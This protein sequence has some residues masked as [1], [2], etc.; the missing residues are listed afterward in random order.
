MRYIVPRLNASIAARCK[1][2][3][4]FSLKSTFTMLWLSSPI[5]LVGCLGFT[6]ASSSSKHI[7]LVHFLNGFHNPS[8]SASPHFR[9][10]YY[11]RPALL[12]PHFCPAFYPCDTRTPAPPHLPNA[13]VNPL[14]HTHIQYRHLKITHHSLLCSQNIIYI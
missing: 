8:E 4:S 9:P 14:K 10:A 13:P 1:V 6:G 2:F 7:H 12:R 11:P 3:C 5:S